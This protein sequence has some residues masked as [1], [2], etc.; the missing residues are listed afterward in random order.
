M[1]KGMAPY[2]LA[3]IVAAAITTGSSSA[4]AQNPTQVCA[5]AL[6]QFEA[7]MKWEAVQESWRGTRPGWVAGLNGARSAA[8][9]ASALGVLEVAMKWEAVDASWRGTR[10]GWVAS[11]GAATTPV[12]VAQ[13]LLVL[14]QATTW[15]AMNDSWRAS[16]PG[17]VAS[18]QAIAGGAAA[19]APQQAV[20]VGRWSAGA[21]VQVLWNGTW[22]ASTILAVN[23]NG[24]FRIHYDGWASSWDEDVA[25]DRIR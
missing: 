2:A 14:E 6:L 20:P 10:P 18:L 15:E 13:L 25:A 23:G 4:E 5:R 17:W 11:V 19:P 16:R 22:Y 8:Q 1:F 21:H 24:T 9:V 7:E 3:A 12:Q